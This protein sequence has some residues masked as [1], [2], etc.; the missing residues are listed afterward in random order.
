M[1][2]FIEAFRPSCIKVKRNIFRKT[3]EKKIG[4]KLGS[5]NRLTE[6]LLNVKQ[7]VVKIILSSHVSKIVLDNGD[8][9]G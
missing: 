1:A 8:D 3:F 4:K 7:T 6:R 5:I 9:P 2:N